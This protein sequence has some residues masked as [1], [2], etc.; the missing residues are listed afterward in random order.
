MTDGRKKGRMTKGKQTVASAVEKL[1]TQG[2]AAKAASHRLAF[3][4]T[5]IK[6]KALLNIA[7][8]LLARKDEILKAN[9]KDIAAAKASG[10]NEA[11]L[12]RLLLNE[13]RLEDMARDVRTVA[14]LPD[15]VGEVFDML[16]L[17]NGLL[18]GRKRVPLGVIATIYESRPNVTVDISVL[19]L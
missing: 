6:N 17:P 13:G 12:E 19:C 4:S 10:M 18:R 7:D 5:G 16:T 1:N 3:I 15:P 9:K 2:K 11:I 8:D 14:G